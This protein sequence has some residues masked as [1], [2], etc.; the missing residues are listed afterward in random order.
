M[1]RNGL[2]A[3]RSHLLQLRILGQNFHTSGDGLNIEW[4]TCSGL[5]KGVA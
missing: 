2:I 4:E 5:L 3:P 1:H